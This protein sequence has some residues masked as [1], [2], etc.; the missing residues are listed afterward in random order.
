M[1]DNPEPVTN[2]NTHLIPKTTFEGPV[3]E[4][5]FPSL[6]IGVAE[7][8][9]GPTGC[10]VF[11]FPNEAKSVVD[12]RGGMSGTIQGVAAADGSVS[13]ICFAGGSLYGLEAATGVS[14]EVFAQSRYSGIYDVRGAII[15]DFFRDTGSIPIKRWVAQLYGRRSRVFFPRCQRRRSFRDLWKMVVETFPE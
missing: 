6:H 7:Y 10:T 13:A 2:D 15:Y 1:V 5:D 11:Y 8:E 12:I 9:E 3:L 14:A 4:F